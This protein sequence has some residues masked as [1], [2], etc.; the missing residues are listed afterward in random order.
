MSDQVEFGLGSRA[1]FQ[2]AVLLARSQLGVNDS[3][4]AG[5]DEGRCG[6]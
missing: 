6:A 1:E 4:E 5:S 3:I 2:R